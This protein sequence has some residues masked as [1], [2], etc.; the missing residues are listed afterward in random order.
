[1]QSSAAFDKAL[2]K[3]DLEPIIF[4]LVLGEDGPHWAFEQAKLV[5][6]WYRRFHF[7]V[8][9][10]PE[11]VIVPSKSL[12]TFWHYHILDT[13]K[14]HDDCM[15]LHGRFVHHFPY[16]GVR[17]EDDRRALESA[18][19]ETDSLYLATFG[20]SLRSANLAFTAND[21][22][23]KS[24]VCGDCSASCAK[25]VMYGRPRIN[26]RHTSTGDSALRQ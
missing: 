15:A 3:L 24:S 18:F 14:Y 21:E 23:R 10:Y 7:L 6:V 16:F 11:K 19:N 1:M 9:R 17:G 25:H 5:E 8:F 22:G 2:G 20:E 13:H 26:G 12:D 4:N